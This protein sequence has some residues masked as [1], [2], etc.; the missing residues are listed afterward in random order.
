MMGDEVSNVKHSHNGDKGHD[1]D[2]ILLKK[3]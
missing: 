3:Q 2:L 1:L